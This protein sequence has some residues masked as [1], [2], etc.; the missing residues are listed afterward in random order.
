[1][2]I[3]CVG[4]TAV[5]WIVDAVLRVEDAEWLITQYKT[6]QV[7]LYAGNISNSG[8]DSAML[9]KDSNQCLVTQW[10]LEIMDKVHN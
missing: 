6:P 2:T 9:I 3:S 4:M 1:M 7:H 5:N 10:Q 8:P